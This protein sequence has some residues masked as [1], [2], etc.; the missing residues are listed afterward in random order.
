MSSQKK[1][2]GNTS[3][4]LFEETFYPIDEYKTTGRLPS[5]KIMIGRMLFLT[6]REPC[7]FTICRKVASKIVAKEFRT[8]WINKNVYPIHK[9][10]LAKKIQKDWDHFKSLKN[11]LNCDSKIKSEKFLLGANEFVNKFTQTAYDNR[12]TDKEYQKRM[13][14]DF[15]VNMTKDDDEFYMDNCHGPYNAVILFQKIGKGSRDENLKD[16]K[17][18]K[19]RYLKWKLKMLNNWQ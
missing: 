7:Y 17:G 12:C 16:K 9:H 6:R 4:K 10:R 5:G 14:A 8:D 19:E 3:K 11:A 2:R 13:E 15:D 1:T 18:P